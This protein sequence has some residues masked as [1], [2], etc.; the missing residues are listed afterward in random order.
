MLEIEFFRFEIPNRHN[1]KLSSDG[2]I[3]VSDGDKSKII[4]SLLC[5]SFFPYYYFISRFDKYLYHDIYEPSQKNYH[6]KL[7]AKEYVIILIINNKL[8]NKLEKNKHLH[9]II[10]HLQ[11]SDLKQGSKRLCL[12]REISLLSNFIRTRESE[13]CYFLPW[14][15]YQFDEIYGY[16]MINK[17]L[18]RIEEKKK[19]FLRRGGIIEGINPYQV[20]SDNFDNIN[21]LIIR[22]SFS[23]HTYEY[24]TVISYHNIRYI[25]KKIFHFKR[26]ILQELMINYLPAVIDFLN[27]CNCNII[28]WVI[29]IM[30]LKDYFYSTPLRL[31]HLLTISNIWIA[32]DDSLKR[33]HKNEL[34]RYL[35][36]K[37]SDYYFVCKRRSINL[38]TL[39]N[40]HEIIY[41]P[42]TYEYTVLKIY[43]KW[44]D[45]WASNLTHDPDNIYSIIT[46]EKMKN[47][48]KR[49]Y[50]SLL[51]TCFL[52]TNSEEINN[53]LN[54]NIN[55]KIDSYISHYE[56]L[57]PIKKFEN[58]GEFTKEFNNTLHRLKSHRDKVIDIS[59][60]ECP[61]CYSDDKI[62]V[63][64]ICKHVFCIE[65]FLN[66][67]TFA[68]EC[69]L[70][71]ELINVSNAV[72][73]LTNHKT[74]LQK[75]I[76]E[77][78]GNILIYTNLGSLQ[79][80]VNSPNVN[81]I[82]YNLNNVYDLISELPR[83]K[84]IIFYYYDDET[85][86]QKNIQ[87]LSQYILQPMIYHF[88][89][90]NVF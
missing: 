63:V 80:L 57:F 89:L 58:S 41:E 62:N 90:P 8:I 65:C 9:N 7:Y 35:F 38:D 69:P 17:K 75:L 36:T 27:R 61:I 13:Y 21:T 45:K 82:E 15:I 86:M 3:I 51:N 2:L 18:L 68:N 83:V 11:I 33:I 79:N 56:N 23:K 16:D 74:Q 12:S 30:P 50:D 67:M 37:F 32:L 87:F 46:K 44:Y 43:Y 20:I 10:I 1:I 76:N 88:K 5:K 22:P 70:C 25:T 39:V 64:T 72:T 49:L 34:N 73:I 71:R 29:N 52:T 40:Y 26:I 24:A 14:N 54:E 53:K 4:P 42:S 77:L 47:I 55:E 59:K 81:W 28:V 31:R 66:S 6:R 78:K 85:D 84:N 60:K 19:Y 48:Q